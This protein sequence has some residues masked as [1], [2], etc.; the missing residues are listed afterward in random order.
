MVIAVTLFQH[1]N[2][3]VVQYVA[4]DD[5]VMVAVPAA[6]PVTVPP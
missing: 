2:N 5:A 4:P 3:R 6:T 1:H